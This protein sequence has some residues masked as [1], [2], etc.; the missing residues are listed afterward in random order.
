MAANS[1][2]TPRHVSIIM[3]GNGRWAEKRGLPRAEGHR[4]GAKAVELAMRSA[5]EFGV[6]VLSLYA[7]STENWKRSPQ[8]VASLMSLLGEFVDANL[9][10]LL[11]DDIKLVVSGRVN[12]LP[13]PSRDK[14]KH[15]VE[16][17]SGNKSWVLNLALSY[18][19]RAE[20]AA[21]AKSIARDAAAGKLDPR[22]V[23]EKLFAS[24]LYHPEL[25]DPDLMIR[26]SGELRLSNFMLWELAYSELYVTNVLWPDFDRAEFA[27]A[28][29]SFGTRDRRFGGRK[30]EAE[31]C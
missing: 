25:P 30:E 13:N 6:R 26:T 10:T 20:I 2:K 1:P 27:R 24:Y 8:E 3:D 17:T 21:A 22:Q 9:S 31:K 19:G 12:D 23:D 16:A 7:F 29:E 15:A 11:R 4:A 18:G 14:L 5:R 28:L